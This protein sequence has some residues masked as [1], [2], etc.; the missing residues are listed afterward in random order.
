MRFRPDRF[1]YGWRYLHL[2]L[3][4]DVQAELQPL[5]WGVDPEVLP[6]LRIDALAAR[7]T[8]EIEARLSAD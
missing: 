7:L 3:P 4:V 1:D 2:D 8:A 6:L 5:T